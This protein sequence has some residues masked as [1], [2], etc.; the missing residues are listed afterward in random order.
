MSAQIDTFLPVK[1]S[2]VA[3]QVDSLYNF[4]LGVSAF[5]TVLAIVLVILFAIRYRRRSE[6]QVPEA[7]P[8]HS[9][10]EFV[11]AGA[12]TILVMIMFFWGA[13][14]FFALRQAPANSAEVLV[15]GKQWMWKIQH[16]S[17]KREI[18]E[19]HVPVGQPVK[20]TMTSE[21]V[22]HDFY[23]P[24]FRTKMD[25]VP[26]RYTSLWFEPTQL[27]NFHIFCAQYCGNEHSRMT[28]WIHV[29]TTNDFEKWLQEP[30]PASL[31]DETAIQAGARLFSQIGCVTCHSRD[32]MIR[33]PDLTK[34]PD[35]TVVLMDGSQVVADD[36]YMRESI[37]SSQS[38]RVAGFEPIMPLYKGLLTEEQ[39]MQLI[40][41][42]RSLSTAGGSDNGS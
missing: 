26:G 9:S 2:T 22:I 8:E 40:A 41:Y 24:A 31:P 39:V 25:V 38:K 42:I 27:G 12:L 20:L 19:L 32:S 34:V 17:G 10:L 37:L 30:S 33:G 1:A 23:I 18:N 3:G 36:A 16:A 29:M 15:V 11:C 14:S 21:D 4:I 35:S 13:R 7:P 6:A 28:G 5:F